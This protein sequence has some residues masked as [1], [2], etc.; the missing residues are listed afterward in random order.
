MVARLTPENDNPPRLFAKIAAPVRY[1]VK[2]NRGADH[3]KD[4]L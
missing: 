3:A 4:G 2:R 1:L